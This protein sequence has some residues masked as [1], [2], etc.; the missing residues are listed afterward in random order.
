[1]AEIFCKKIKNWKKMFFFIVYS[2]FSWHCIWHITHRTASIFTNFQ[3]QESPAGK[4]R[5]IVCTNLM[6][7][8]TRPQPLL[9]SNF[10]FFAKYLRHAMPC[11]LCTHGMVWHMAH[12]T[13]HMAHCHPVLCVATLTHCDYLL[14]F[15]H[16]NISRNVVI[17]ENSRSIEIFQI[18]LT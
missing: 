11:H 2:Y 16:P 5:D 9:T 6:L 10:P 3:V 1:M 17:M 14:A 4:I 13:W 18:L 8:V 7:E 15:Y 12:R